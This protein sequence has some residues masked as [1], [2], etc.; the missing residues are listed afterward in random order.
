VVEKINPP[1]ENDVPG[2]IVAAKDG[3]VVDVL[4]VMGEARVHAGDTVSRGQ[5][6]IEGLLVP[7]SPYVDPNDEDA[8]APVPVH[9]RGE[10]LARVWYE[11]YGEANTV[12][13]KRNRTGKRFIAWSIIVDGQSVLRVGRSE[14]P[15]ANYELTSIKQR[16]P[17]RVFRIPVEIIT[18]YMYEIGL[19]QVRLTDEQAL[20]QA[21]ERARILTEFQLPVGVA[22]ESVSLKE[23]ETGTGNLVGVRYI[24]ET[25]E[26]IAEEES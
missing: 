24:I 21:A 9:A 16:L 15:Y 8:P 20:D 13:V 2:N 25:I 4:V 23:V 26:N 1:V 12:F 7:Q 6:L 17:E 18:E 22:A 14:V 10:V 5:L 11:G 3:L 19:E